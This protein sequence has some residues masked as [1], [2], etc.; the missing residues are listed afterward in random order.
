MIN[1]IDT[2]VSTVFHYAKLK[3]AVNRTFLIFTTTKPENG[4]N[5]MQPLHVEEN[6][7]TTGNT[8][9]ERTCQKKSFD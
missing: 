1:F 2:L 5:L 7:S 3:M 8:D 6:N 9:S 4:N